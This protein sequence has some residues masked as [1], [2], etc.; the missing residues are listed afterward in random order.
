MR[1]GSAEQF[2]QAGRAGD[3]GEGTDS[4]VAHLDRR[5]LTILQ[6]IELGVGV[7]TEKEIGDGL[8]GLAGE[9]T[10]PASVEAP[11]VETLP[12]PESTLPRSSPRTSRC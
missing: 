2:E 11:A 4:R 12:S 1:H 8:R 7:G 5:C 6:V 9:D 3:G 10:R